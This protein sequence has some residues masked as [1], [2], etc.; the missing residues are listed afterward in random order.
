MTMPLEKSQLS[1][2]ARKWA[3]ILKIKKFPMWPIVN[4]ELSFAEG[5]K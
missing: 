4:W 3:A 5:I 2:L 1:F